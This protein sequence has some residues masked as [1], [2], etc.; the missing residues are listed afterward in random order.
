MR[1]KIPVR[2]KPVIKEYILDT[3]GS[4]TIVPKKG[5]LLWAILKKHLQ[6]PPAN[7]HEPECSTDE[8]IFIE[9]LDC[10][11]TTTLV[12]DKFVHINTLFRWYVDPIGVA[13]I[14]R[15]LSRNFKSAMHCFIQGALAA[16][17]EMQQRQ[18]M[19]CFC[20]VH[21]LTMQK[22]SPEM[23]K[24]SWDRSAHKQKL[25]DRSAKVNVIFF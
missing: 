23:I 15:I 10:H 17:P 20:D 12:G 5:D 2:V 6:T 7:Y 4:D 14:N 11:N 24:K 13:N 18:A 21:N 19:E 1:M 22:I 3:T 16:N 25:F 8:T 9:L